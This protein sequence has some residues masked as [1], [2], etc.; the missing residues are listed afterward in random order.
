MPPRCPMAFTPR[1]PAPATTGTLSPTGTLV[2][3]DV[4]ERDPRSGPTSPSPRASLPA[5]GRENRATRPAR[6]PDASP[7]GAQISDDWL[8]PTADFGTR[9]HLSTNTHLST[10]PHFPSP[11][12]RPTKAGSNQAPIQKGNRTMTEP[13]IVGRR[14]ATA[15]SARTSPKPASTGSRADTSRSCGASRLPVRTRS[16]PLRPS[17]AR[18]TG[19]LRATA[20]RSRPG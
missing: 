7:T 9:A 16:S 8:P 2:H 5:R 20:S 10:P 19:P 11:K 4:P 14:T 18:T 3:G 13:I 12:P 15:P 6:N 17:R 1:R